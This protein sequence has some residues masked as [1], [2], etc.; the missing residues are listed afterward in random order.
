MPYEQPTINTNGM[1]LFDTTGLLLK[2]G[3]FNESMSVGFWTPTEENG[4]K[5][6][7][8]EKRLSFI[9]TKERVSA[10]YDIIINKVLP[11]YKEGVNYNGGVFITMK[12]D[13]VFEIRV[14]G[15]NIFAV[16]HTDID[17]DRKPKNSCVFAFNKTPIIENYNTSTGEFELPTVDADFYLFVKAVE[18]YVIAVPNGAIA[19]S[20]KF[21]NHFEDNLHFKYLSSIAAKL[22]ATPPS[23]YNNYHANGNAD[24]WNNN[25]NSSSAPTST[26]INNL[27]DAIY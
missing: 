6:Y 25:G 23:N 12:K 27:E 19:Q 8:K 5:T 14:E 13:S 4:K 9:L 18:S 11:A 17:A 22:G 26:E 16:Y 10:L 24:A 1:S 15:G 2:I 21:H 3:F 7:P 20:I